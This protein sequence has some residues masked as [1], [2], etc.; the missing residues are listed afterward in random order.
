MSPEINKNK[1]QEKRVRRNG[2]TEPTH[3]TMYPS[4]TTT[5]ATVN[6]KY[7]YRNM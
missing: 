5:Q 3:P 7:E 2:D 4:I 6:Y 1:Q